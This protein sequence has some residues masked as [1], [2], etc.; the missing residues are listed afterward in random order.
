MDY[1]IAQHNFKGYNFHC[2]HDFMSTKVISVKFKY[3]T[4]H[5]SHG[6][7]FKNHPPTEIIQVTAILKNK[8]KSLKIP[9]LFQKW[10]QNH[11]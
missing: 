8:Q 2:F 11:P 5:Y 10:L 4:L 1:R 3:C 9:V 6:L 7:F